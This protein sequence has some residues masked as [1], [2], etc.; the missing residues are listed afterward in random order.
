MVNHDSLNFGKL[1]INQLWE[2]FLPIHIE[3]CDT[4]TS[5]RDGK[6]KCWSIF[7]NKWALKKN[8]VLERYIWAGMGI[9]LFKAIVPT[10]PHLKL[11]KTIHLISTG[12]L[13]TPLPMWFPMLRS[14]INVEDLQQQAKSFL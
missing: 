3:Y 7:E 14:A 2:A 13:T 6:D 9:F 5:T 12:L 10:P 4:E 1:Q 8:N 11:T